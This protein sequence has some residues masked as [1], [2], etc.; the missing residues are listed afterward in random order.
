M[1]DHLFQKKNY[2]EQWPSPRGKK[3]K[4]QVALQP[5]CLFHLLMAANGAPIAL[6]NGNK[7]S[8]CLVLLKVFCPL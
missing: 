2:S 3:Y 5:S 4:L 7:C 1:I 6:P 8:L